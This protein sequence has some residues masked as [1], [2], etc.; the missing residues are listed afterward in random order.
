VVDA[1]VV[2]TQRKADGKIVS[3]AMEL[4]ESNKST[5][6]DTK[7]ATGAMDQGRWKTKVFA[8]NARERDTFP[9]GNLTDSCIYAVI[10]HMKSYLQII[11]EEAQQYGI[12]LLKAFK[13]AD[14]PTSTYY[15]TIHGTTE[16]RHET[17]AKVMKAI[18]KIHSL[19]QAREYTQELRASGGKPDIREIRSRF[20][21]RSTSA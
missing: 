13:A 2:S 14:I 15:R 17:A 3:S 20:K 19:Q 12:E 9:S 5:S 21:P 10:C 6:L 1:E 7:T 8:I 11:E 18:A 4:N 16:L